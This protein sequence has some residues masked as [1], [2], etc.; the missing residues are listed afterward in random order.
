[1]SPLVEQVYF[2]LLKENGSSKAIHIS[3]RREFLNFLNKYKINNT[4]IV[5]NSKGNKVQI[6]LPYINL[7][8]S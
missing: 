7:I 5:K 2:N 6:H 1:M 8:E 3:L 4:I